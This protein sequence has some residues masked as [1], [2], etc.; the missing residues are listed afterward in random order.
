MENT[1]EVE[2][3]RKIKKIEYVLES[4]ILIPILYYLVMT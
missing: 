1:D 3:I 4:I 2:N